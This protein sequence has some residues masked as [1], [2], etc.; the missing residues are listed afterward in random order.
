MRS[1]FNKRYSDKSQ[2]EMMTIIGNTWQGMSEAERAPFL[3]LSAEET[4]QYEKE[5]SMLEKA[6]RPNEMWQPLRRCLKVLD[7]LAEDPF[8][9]IF[10][11]PVNMND[12]PDY[13][14]FIDT[15]MDISTVRAKLENK[16]YMA[17]EQFARDMRRV[18]THITAHA[19]V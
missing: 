12:F 19:F 7:R 8:A 11:E 3:Q 15:P 5:C 1:W 6:Q 4:K 2:V 13:D 17:V 18:S 14:E 9:D 16:K 10:L